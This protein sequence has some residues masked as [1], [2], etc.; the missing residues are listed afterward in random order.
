MAILAVYANEEKRTACSSCSSCRRILYTSI[1]GFF[2]QSPA[3]A[4]ADL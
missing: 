1:G 3:A 4:D 2:Q